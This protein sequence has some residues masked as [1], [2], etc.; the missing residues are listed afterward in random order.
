M[1]ELLMSLDR[2]PEQAQRVTFLRG[3]PKLLQDNSRV[4]RCHEIMSCRFCNTPS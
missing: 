3:L 2:V 1:G 4:M